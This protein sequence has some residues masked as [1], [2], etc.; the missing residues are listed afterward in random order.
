VTGAL[1]GGCGGGACGDTSIPAF[2]TSTQVSSATCS[3]ATVTVSP[4]GSAPSA[5]ALRLHGR[6]FDDSSTGRSARVDVSRGGSAVRVGGEK[7]VAGK[8]VQGG[9]KLT[10]TQAK[11]TIAR[12]EE[13]EA[14]L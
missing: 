10:K 9:S 11:E 13:P 5:Q 1:A 2:D 12:F 3:S 7:F 8:A 6:P 14:P 4:G